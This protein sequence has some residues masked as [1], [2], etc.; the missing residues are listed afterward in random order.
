[1]TPETAGEPLLRVE[2]LKV[3][4]PVTRGLLRRT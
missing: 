1:M 2:G 3:H 4:F